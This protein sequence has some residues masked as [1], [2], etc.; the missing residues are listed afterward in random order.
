MRTR[1]LSEMLILDR[2]AIC[3]NAYITDLRASSP[4]EC[5]KFAT[6]FFIP[7]NEVGLGGAFGRCD[8]HPHELNAPHDTWK[9]VFYDEFMVWEVMYS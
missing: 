2:L 5:G 7:I 4:I 9:E 3:C 1:P 6:R 8:E